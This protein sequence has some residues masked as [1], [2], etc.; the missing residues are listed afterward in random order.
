MI[1]VCIPTYNG[2]KYIRRQLDSILVQL[3]EGDEVI[4][5]DD[6]STDN[7]V[8][9]IKG[10]NDKRI[11]FIEGCMFKSPVFNLENAL[12]HAKG[13]VVFLSDQDDVWLPGKVKTMMKYLIDNDIVVSDCIVVDQDEKIIKESF[14]DILNS[15]NGFTKNCIRNS[16]LGCCMAFKRDLLRFFLPFPAKIAM[17]DIWMGLVG[18]VFGKPI[19]IA[20]KLLLYRR[21]DL[22]MTQPHLKSRNGLVFKITYRIVMLYYLLI[23]ILRIFMANKIR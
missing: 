4:I 10:Y 11:T 3:N 13:E 6:S 7:T 8:D 17:H 18:E 12:K 23:R 21:H 1:S 16:Y 5:S 20:D 22:N 19:F 15:G 9:I 14:F 2:E